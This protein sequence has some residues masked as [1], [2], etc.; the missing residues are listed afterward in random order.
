MSDNIY[1]GNPL[2]KKAN[3]SMEF[4]QEQILE[5]MRCKDDPVYFAKNYVRIVTLD[6]GLMPFDLYPFQEKLIN[7]FHNHRFNICKMPRQTGKST[8][9]VSYL[10]HYAVFNDNVNIGILQ[11]KQQQQ[12]NFW[13]VFKQH[14]KIFLSGC[15][16]VSFLGTKVH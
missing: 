14:M 12:E 11:T 13:I 2:L 10:L 6:H 1:L 15:S 3:T 16:K 8:T 9:V 5:F 7:N 4:T